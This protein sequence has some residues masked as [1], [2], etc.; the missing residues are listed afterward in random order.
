M[1]RF[2]NENNVYDPRSIVRT[3]EKK[4][5]KIKRENLNHEEVNSI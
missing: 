5:I 4:S 1:D 3:T 2:G